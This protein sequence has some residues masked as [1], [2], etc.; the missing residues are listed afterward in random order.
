MSFRPSMMCS[1]GQRR[2]PLGSTSCTCPPP[3]PSR[4]WERARHAG[5]RA[6]AETCPHYL[7]LD[8]SALAALGP[9]AKCAPPLRSRADVEA[10]WDAVLRGGI[11]TIGSDHAP[12]SSEE[13]AAG[14]SSIWDAPN[15]LTGIQTMLPLLVDEGVHRRG[16][17]WDRLARLLATNTAD[18][19]GLPQK[20][21]IAV[22]ADADLVLVDPDA[23][24]TIRGED[25]LSLAIWTP[26]EG[27][28]VR[29]RVRSTVL[30]GQLVWHL[31]DIR[32]LPGSAQLLN[33]E[34][35]RTLRHQGTHGTQ[36]P[37]VG[38]QP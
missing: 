4:P 32:A 25:L 8:D 17:T 9:W 7:V 18:I 30:R 19:F 20:G 26:Y 24:W 34:A 21:R 13:K 12:F 16:L 23:E 15:G 10:L 1:R 3:R 28:R 2:R 31:G 5:V 29:G 22:G 33:L 37:E 36:G 14:E 11:D 35:D 27:R 38:G 6:H